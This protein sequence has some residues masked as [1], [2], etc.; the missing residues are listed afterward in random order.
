MARRPSNRA[1]R[2]GGELM[3]EL[4]D[5]LRGSMRD[6][7][8]SGVTITGVDVVAD[9]SFARVHFVAHDDADAN[10]LTAVLNRAVP[11]LRGELARRLLVRQVPGL[12]FL[13]DAT[14]GEGLRMDRLIDEAMAGTRSPDD[15]A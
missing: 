14:I 8:L 7:R 2:L 13:F 12:R 4:S 11:F 1:R 15:E 6:P 10:E 9:L 3:R 5:I